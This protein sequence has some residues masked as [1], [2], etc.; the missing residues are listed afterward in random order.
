MK[1]Q[2]PHESHAPYFLIDTHQKDQRYAYKLADLLAERGADV[3]F[4]KESRDPTESL[5]GFERA[6]QDVQISSSCSGG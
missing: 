6:V 2:A 4:N 3:D 5:R 1:A